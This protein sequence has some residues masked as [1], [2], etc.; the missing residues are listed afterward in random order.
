MAQGHGVRRSNFIVDDS[1]SLHASAAETATGDSALIV[2]LGG[3]DQPDSPVM[4]FDVAVDVSAIDAVTGDESYRLILEGSS[5]AT[6]ASDIETLAE[7]SL[8]GGGT[9]LLANSDVAS[10]VG[11]YVICG[12][13]ERNGRTY[14]YVRLTWVIAGTTPSVTFA[15]SLAKVTY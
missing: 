1:L 15:A 13:N 11:R 8:Y 7:L 5:S 2:D 10:D 9:A 6:F 14:R 3:G 12:S 4:F